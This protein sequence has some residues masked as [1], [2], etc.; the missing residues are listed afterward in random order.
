[1]HKSESL[2]TCSEPCS[3]TCPR[4]S[5]SCQGPYEPPLPLWLHLPCSSPAPLLS[6]SISHISHSMHSPGSGAGLQVFPYL[7]CFLQISTG[8]YPN[9]LEVAHFRLQQ[10]PFNQHVRSPL[11]PYAAPLFSIAVTFFMEAFII[12]YRKRGFLH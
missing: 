12:L 6:S 9:A 11:S 7:E 1:M 10:A 5:Q 3:S 4:K 2:L 8:L